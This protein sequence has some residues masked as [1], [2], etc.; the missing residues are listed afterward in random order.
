MKIRTIWNSDID[1]TPELIQEYRD[2]HEDGEPELSEAKILERIY[3]D[4]NISFQDEMVNLDIPLD[5]PILVIA[6]LGLYDG[7]HSGYRIIRA[8]VSA[9][10]GVRLGDYTHYYA[11][12][13]NVRCDD[14]HHDGTNHYLFRELRGDPDECSPLIEAIYA[15]KEISP[16]ML[17][18]YSRSLLPY[19][20]DVY[21]WPVAGRKR[22]A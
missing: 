7:R 16:A 19:V 3:E 9:I 12:A 6:D 13:Y 15:G 2:N 20:A 11:D 4:N 8:N 5:H 21:G 18:R 10:L 14:I 17:N 1:I 22:S